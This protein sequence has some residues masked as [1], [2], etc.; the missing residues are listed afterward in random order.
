M[1]LVRFGEKGQEKPGLIDKAG[2]I[3]DVS[4]LTDDFAG[5]ALSPENLANIAAADPSALPEVPANTRLGAPIARTSHF[6]AVGLNYADHAE[7]TGMDIPPEPLL[8]TKAP[9]C[10]AGPNDPL[11]YPEGATKL[12]WE[13]E[14]AV[15]IGRRAWQIDEMEAEACI[16]GYTICN[17]I[18]ERAWQLEGSGQWLK[19]KSA[20]GFGPIGP[21]L[22]TPDDLKTPHDLVMHLSVNGSVMQ[23][24]ST[25]TMVYKVPELIAF[26]ASRFV[27]EPGD[28]ITTGTPPGVGMGKK[29]PFFLQRG[30]IMRA[31]IEGLGIQETA[32]I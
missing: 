26:C 28:I 27:L 6:I 18:S 17:D 19:G 22:V 31:E 1:R 16:A 30:D 29:P 9:S 8:F 10:L 4:S 20:P 12:D 7:E 5:E 13:V 14:L 15:V 24:G 3:R 25:R 11:T 21:M 2:I 23:A 32:V